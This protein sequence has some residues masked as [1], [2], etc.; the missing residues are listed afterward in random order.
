MTE[1]TFLRLVENVLDKYVCLI[2]DKTEDNGIIGILHS[3]IKEFKEITSAKLSAKIEDTIEKL[4]YNDVT[5]STYLPALTYRGFVRVDIYKTG[6][7]NRILLVII[8]IPDG[9]RTRDNDK[10]NRRVLTNV[11]IITD[12]FFRDVTLDELIEDVITSLVSAI[13]PNTTPDSVSKVIA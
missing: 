5:Y 8:R 12:K 4:Y 1:K 9:G 2:N 3:A 10:L 11:H 6:F 13:D 7:S